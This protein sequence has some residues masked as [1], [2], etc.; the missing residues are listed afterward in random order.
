[1]VNAPL[2]IADG[3]NGKDFIQAPVNLKHC[4]DVKI[5]SAVALAD[6]L[7]AV[8]HFKAHEVA[9]FGGAIKN[10]GMGCGSRGGKQ[11]MHSD[12]LPRIKEEK[13]KGCGKC[14]QWCPTG[15]IA[16]GETKKAAIDKNICIGCGECTVTCP[17]RAISINWRSD[18]E[19]GM[20][21]K[22]VEYAAGVL[23]AKKGKCGFINFLN[24]ISPD[25][26]CYG[27]TDAPVVRDIGILASLDP[28]AIDQACIDLV[29]REKGLPGTKLEGNEDTEDKFAAIHPGID[30]RRQLAYGE[31][32]GLGSRKYE[33]IKLK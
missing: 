1:V 14:N 8:T 15:A 22:M 13:C 29:N 12:L 19:Y 23:S 17:H 5:G 4:K 6:A 10:V 27:F 2:I 21:E 20:Q 7:I 32:I 26:D 24:N 25:C 3:L 33:L 16:V 30:W 18:M 11:V 9:G 28:I 31:E